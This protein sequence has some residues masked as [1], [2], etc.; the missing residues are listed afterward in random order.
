LKKIINGIS[1]LFFAVIFITIALTVFVGSSQRVI[2]WTAQKYAPEYDFSYTHISG[3]LFSGI[4]VK[5]LAFKDEKLM[6]TIGFAWSPLALLSNR[7]TINK[8]ELLG[9]EVDALKNTAKAFAS[10]EPKS[11][12]NSSFVMPM[13][14]EVNNIDISINS[15]EEENITIN[16]ITLKSKNILFQERLDIERLL[17]NIDTNISTLAIDATL[18]D[19]KATLSKLSL[20]EVDLVQIRQIIDSL[21]SQEDS[22]GSNSSTAVAEKKS[23]P[24]PLMPT[25]LEVESL[26]IAINPAK[27]PEVDIAKA[28]LDIESIT[29]DMLKV[30]TPT[31]NAIEVE[32][33]R[34]LV[35]TN[36]SKLSLNASLKDEKV[37]VEELF[38]EEI[39]TLA[40]EKLFV[41]KESNS[42]DINNRESN[43]TQ[44]EASEPSPFVPKSLE[45]KKF[46]TSIKQALYD[47]IDIKSLQIDA[48]EF[49]FDIHNLIAKDGAID[50]NAI[51]NLATLEY[52]ISIIDNQIKSKGVAT[53]L[54]E[55]FAKYTLREGGVEPIAFVVDANQSHVDAKIAMNGTKILVAKEGEF[56]VEKL[57]FVNRLH[58]NIPDKKLTLH[59]KANIQTPYAKDILL[60]NNFVLDGE[61]FYFKG[62]LLPGK[63]EALDA[64]QSKPLQDLTI[65]Y[66]G[67]NSSIEAYIDSAEL[68]GQLISSDF[69][70]GDFNLSTKKPLV[71]QE[72]V[73]LPPKLEKTKLEFDINAPLDFVNKSSNSATVKILS[74]LV[75]FDATIDYN[76]SVKVQSTTSFP[77]NSLLRDFD[78]ALHLDKI[79]PLK[80]D[81]QMD[82]K[83]IAVD[84]VSNAVNAKAM[85]N[86]ENQDI[87]GMLDVVK[88]RI[89]FD[90]NLQNKVILKH[91]IP[92]IKELVARVQTLYSF[93]DPKIGGDVNLSI[94]IENASK[95]DITLAS[96]QL[97]IKPD[98]KTEHII[99]DT[100][101]SL[102]FVDSNLTLKSYH[103]T[104]QEQKIFATKPSFIRLKESRVDITPFWLN[105]A[106]QIRGNY[107]LI[108]KKGDIIL[109]ADTFEVSHKM[110]DLK[111]KIDIKATIDGIKT[112][113]D[114]KV[115]IMG[116]RVYLDMDKRSF[117]TDSDII[118]V[119]NIKK[120]EASPFMENLI[121]SL[122]IDTQKPLVYKT[123]DADIKLKTDVVVQQIGATPLAV[124][125][126]A[127]I[128]DGSYYM[129][130]EKNFT[131]KDSLIAF[132][133]DPSKPILDIM[134]LYNSLYY[135]IKIQVTGDPQTP[136]LIF[137]S[138][139]RLTRE[140]ILSVILF[141]NEDAGDSSSGDEMMKM[142]GGAIAKSALSGV[143]IKI[144]HLSLGTDGSME[145]GK[146][147]S[148][149]VTIIY[150][151]DEVSSARLQYDWNKNIKSNIMSDGES[152]GVDI[153]YRREF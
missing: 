100:M 108:D 102:E 79:N 62:S 58:Y 89:V 56:N 133:G 136:N 19:Q 43:S 85:Y 97:R 76:K 13:A 103:T 41:P 53:P 50:I 109:Y 30:L 8:L 21:Q 77:A 78:K 101:F 135:E 17:L 23:T 48:K 117:A 9:V 151:N 60:D 84:I 119:Q 47:D 4:E 111:S 145:V 139:P 29:V 152:S 83:S 27:F 31:K 36:L 110:I 118:I 61:K 57:A 128:M 104:F 74:N 20:E 65:S 69:K 120:R 67:N 5:D 123:S 132:V 106:L 88:E 127:T 86:L 68:Q 66:E 94:S 122:I 92:N 39:D 134:A 22:N 16:S 28:S 63:L 12:D 124:Y 2:E 90:G 126:T 51:S 91:A 82:D 37:L 33:I 138:V 131:L 26:N 52:S 70:Q 73:T 121:L 80:S 150:S 40:L 46:H 105:D 34:L 144:D 44:V 24:S 14:L 87:R 32:E 10:D 7:V 95:L 25:A 149:K 64:N 148:D 115:T 137:S 55:L 125:G 54:K 18:Q 1:Y 99:D 49:I 6:D 75:N 114:G 42:T 96:N 142:M 45:L 130:Q 147:I 129:F 116:G 38:I 15:F 141:D 3:T 143:G 153:I 146:K 59:N 113:V 107:N 112:K 11:E 71:L 81:I 98:K 140:Q 35:D 72:L 93:E